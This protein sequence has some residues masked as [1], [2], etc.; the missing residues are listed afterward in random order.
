VA[1]GE[2][3]L[4][5][6]LFFNNTR[7]RRFTGQRVRALPDGKKLSARL[8]QRAATVIL[9][10]LIVSLSAG[11]L[12]YGAYLLWSAARAAQLQPNGEAIVL[13]AVTNFFDTLGIGSFAPT[14]AWMKFR[15]LVPDRL[16]PLTM[17]GG[18]I[19][20]AIVQA[21]I[22]L[23][24]LG[25]EIDPR[26][27]LS[28]IVAMVV[29]GIV[30]VPIAAR[31][32]IQ[33]VQGVVGLALLVAAFFYSLSNLGLMP[34]GGNAI[35]L[36]IHW[37]MVAVAVHFLLGVLVCF[38]VGNYA[39]TLAMLSLMG[40]D[41]RL[42][43]PIMAS[44]A[45]FAGVAAAGRSIHL[46]K[47]DYRIVLGLALG[48]IPAVLVAAFIVKEMPI[49]LLRWLVV[50]VVSY[51]GGTLLLGATRRSAVAPPEFVETAILD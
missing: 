14:I 20:P 3:S 50:V 28:C 16:M 25:V 31:A 9:T 4:E 39:P 48:A 51:A 5:L 19:L 42:A 21:I 7:R 11:A 1:A 10:F 32:P 47:L 22:F 34:T 35:S 15:R 33:V 24:L 30:G 6:R 18:Y 37:A 17:L 26:L 44:A 2:K 46:V 12:S 40:M 27:L 45:S 29:G 49:T 36:P 43:F 23:A 13:G 41:P 38:G 8:R